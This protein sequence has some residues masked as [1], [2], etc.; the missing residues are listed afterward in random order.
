M[1]LLEEVQNYLDMTWILSEEEEK[2]LSGMIERGMASI[3]GKIGGCDFES[4][5]QEKTLLFNY[6]MYERAGAL[7]DFWENYKSEIISL[8]LRNKVIAYEEVQD[9]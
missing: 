1:N 2:K 9:I 7:A 6:V 3:K 5:T 4:E 8:R